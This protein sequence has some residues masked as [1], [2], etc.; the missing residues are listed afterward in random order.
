[1]VPCNAF[2]GRAIVSHDTRL[3]GWAVNRALRS[4]LARPVYHQ[5]S[6]VLFAVALTGS[7]H[8]A[9]PEATVACRCRAA[10]QSLSEFGHGDAPRDGSHGRARRV[11]ES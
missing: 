1:M 9:R 8:R 6:T 10:W 7:R 3:P 5:L 2:Q 4:L 11:L